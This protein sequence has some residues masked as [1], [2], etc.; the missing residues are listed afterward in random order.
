MTEPRRITAK[1]SSAGMKL[2]GTFSYDAGTQDFAV[3]EW[4]G[5]SYHSNLLGYGLLANMYVEGPI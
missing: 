1:T 5:T 2:A 3:H 4:G